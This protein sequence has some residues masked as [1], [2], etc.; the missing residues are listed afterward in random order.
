MVIGS[1]VCPARKVKKQGQNDLEKEA[2]VR[3]TTDKTQSTMSR[4]SNPGVSSLKRLPPCRHLPQAN[5]QS[6]TTHSQFS[7]S[8]LS[9]RPKSSRGGIVGQSTFLIGP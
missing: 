2:A 4:Q 1:R 6:R 5:T 9:A 3:L 8:Q 7:Q